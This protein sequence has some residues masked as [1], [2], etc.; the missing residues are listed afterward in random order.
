MT[1]ILSELRERLMMTENGCLALAF[2]SFTSFINTP[3]SPSNAGYQ[4]HS[5]PDCLGGVAFHGD[6]DIL[7]KALKH[8]QDEEAS[9][10]PRPR[11]P[12]TIIDQERLPANIMLVLSR[13]ERHLE[14]WRGSPIFILP[15]ILL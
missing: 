15:E 1:S 11:A 2:G 4:P 3:N 13:G 6:S 12:L 14:A 8:W 10:P 9:N 7:N 5:Y